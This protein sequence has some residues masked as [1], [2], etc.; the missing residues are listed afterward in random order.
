MCSSD[1]LEERGVVIVGSPEEV[2]QGATVVVRTHGVPQS[3]LQ[4]FA[5]TGAEICDAT[6][7]F[8]KK[9]HSIVS[10][11]SAQDIPVLIAGDADHPEVCGIR[12]Y[13]K[14]KTH[15]FKD[16]AELTEILNSH[17]EYLKNRVLVVAQTTFSLE[18]WGNCVKQINLHCTNAVKFDTIC[19]ATQERQTEALELSL[20]CDKMII[21]GGRQSSNTAKLKSVCEANCKTTHIERPEE[22]HGIDLNGCNSI[23]VTAGASTP[24]GT[25]KE[26]LK[27]MSEILK[28]DQIE[29]EETARN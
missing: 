12:G 15:T 25:I 27:T 17:P 18:E 9:I 14:G 20:V 2:A 4:Q 10:E 6:C 22:I 24:S 19:S 29:K 5:D 8:V 16:T 21:I 28:D 1:L 3:V 26:V 7:P 13:C 11:N 23:G